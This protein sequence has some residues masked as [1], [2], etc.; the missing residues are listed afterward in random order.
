MSL[1]IT[2]VILVMLSDHESPKFFV[3]GCKWQCVHWQSVARIHRLPRL[4]KP[5]DCSVL[6][7]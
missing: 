2:E 5:Q 7:E 1:L 3:A 6:A 4:P